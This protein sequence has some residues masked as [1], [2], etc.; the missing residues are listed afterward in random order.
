MSF[1]SSAK[2]PVGASPRGIDEGRG[3]SRATLVLVEARGEPS[4]GSLA[5]R[6]VLDEVRLRMACRGYQWD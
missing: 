6:D 1:L 5:C 4:S 3:L 2:G